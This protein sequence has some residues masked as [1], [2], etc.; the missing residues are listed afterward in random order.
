MQSGLVYWYVKSVN[1]IIAFMQD[2]FRI[3]K[4]IEAVCVRYFHKNLCRRVKID[5]YYNLTKKMQKQFMLNYSYVK[6][7]YVR[8]VSNFMFLVY[9]L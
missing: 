7:I 6:S 2:Q 9:F 5:F 3:L 8:L 4:Y 1:L